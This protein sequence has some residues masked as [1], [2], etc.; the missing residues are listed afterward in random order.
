MS[1]IMH[2]TTSTDREREH[3]C[4]IVWD[5]ET[6]RDM[7]EMIERT[8]GHPCAG[9]VGGSC[10]VL[11]RALSSVAK[12]HANPRAVKAHAALTAIRGYAERVYAEERAAKR[13]MTPEQESQEISRVVSDALKAAGISQRRAA[14][15]TGMSLST[16][17]RRLKDASPLLVTELEVLAELLDTKVST[18]MET[19]EAATA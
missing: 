17:R 6:V 14:A 2:E 8:T 19:A 1:T 11:P 15:Q 7:H 4:S 12:Q 10:P 3:A 5:A 16:L 9:S 18:I 13:T